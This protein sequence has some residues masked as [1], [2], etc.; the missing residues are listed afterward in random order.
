M[1]TI[2]NKSVKLLFSGLTLSL[3]LNSAIAGDYCKYSREINKTM[4]LGAVSNL[5]VEAGAGELIIKG[6]ASRDDILIEAKL[7]SSD[8][9]LL[10]K[11][12]VLS[13]IDGEKAQ[14]RTKFPDKKLSNSFDSTSI[15]LELSVPASMSLE[16]DDSSG[17]ARVLKV[18]ELRMRDSSGRLDIE[19]I[20]GNLSVQDSSGEMNIE[21]VG[22]DVELTDSS[23]GIYVQEIKGNLR[24]IADSSGAIEA[25]DIGKDVIIERD[26][27]GAIEVKNVGGD[28]TVE[29]DSSG[30]IKYRNVTG[31]VSLPD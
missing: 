31:K 16:V 3:F 10:G 17:E 29:K 1:E 5:V 23:G 21:N 6:D 12:D 27:S 13:R 24:V 2:M 9:D 4:D 18:A 30:G 11:M 8:K 22:G 25:K 7:C 14:I 26:S 20:A 28:F 15:D 19:S